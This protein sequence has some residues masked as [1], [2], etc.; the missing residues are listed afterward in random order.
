MTQ[1]TFSARVPIQPASQS[2]SQS[3]PRSPS[4]QAGIFTAQWHARGTA[5]HSAT[6]RIACAAPC[7]ARGADP[8]RHRCASALFCS[9]LLNSG[10]RLEVPFE[11]TVSCWPSLHAHGCHGVCLGSAGRTRGIICLPCACK[12]HRNCE[13]MSC[14]WG[15]T[16]SSSGQSPAPT[17]QQC[18]TRC[19]RCTCTRHN[20]VS[21]RGRARSAASKDYTAHVWA[22]CA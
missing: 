10:I 20:R 16:A 8:P 12:A 3:A 2:A 21:P 17:S 6:Y 18:R 19:T 1:G 4:A 9:V 22:A 15:N 5:P 14:A 13:I 11:C 7:P